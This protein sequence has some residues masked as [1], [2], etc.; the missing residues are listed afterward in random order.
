VSLHIGT[1]GWHYAHWRGGFYPRSLPTGRWLDY[2]A[3]RFATVEI[4][5]A[6]YRLPEATTFA[7]WATT[8]P[9]DFVVAVKASRYLTHI[10][11]LHEPDEPVRRLRE[12]MAGLGSK[13]GPVLLQL[14]PNLTLDPDALAGTL[15][16][17]AGNRVAVEFR[18]ETWYT[19]EIR[20]LLEEHQAALCLTDSRGRR[21]P[22]WRTAGWG[23]V[24]FHGGKA[25][26]PSG[27]G[28]RALHNWAHHLADLWPPGADVYAYFN[29]DQFG[30]APRDARLFALAA[31]QAGLSP[32]RVPSAGETPT[33]SGP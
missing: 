26:P 19:P 13:L 14:P 6:F 15:G 5:N 18:H 3:Q 2:Y 31:R 22:L 7:A 17:L 28:R 25:Q 27:Y 1:S 23:Y 12:R 29:N 10:R 21:T 24:R 33:T 30:C 11:R 4:N 20:R 9:E 32:T 16:A 8:V